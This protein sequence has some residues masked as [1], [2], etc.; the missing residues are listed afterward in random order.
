MENIIGRDEE[1]RR[2]WKILE[3]QSVVLASLRRIGKTY[4]LKKMAAEPQ[5]GWQTILF[6]VQGKKSVEEFVQGLFSELIEKGIVKPHANRVREFYNKWLGGRKPFGDYELPELKQHWKEVLGKML[7]DVAESQKPTLIMLDEFPWMLYELIV[8][9]HTEDE[10]MELLNILRTYR[11]L[12]EGRSKLRF[13]FCGSI[14]INVVLDH[15]VKE[16][17]YLGNPI[18]NMYTYV[19][20]EMGD[21]D[22]TE[23]CNYLGSMYDVKDSGGVFSFIAE[24]VQN[25][26][27]YIDLIFKELSQNGISI[28]SQ[29]D[30]EETVLELIQDIS[31]NGNFDHFRERIES[32]YSPEGRQLAYHL[33]KI[34]TLE[35]RALSRPEL[36]HLIRHENPAIEEDAL[37]DGLKNLARDLYLRM[38]ANGLYSFRYALLQRWWKMHY[39]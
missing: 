16:H 37:N 24:S 4:T 5:E 15:L 38:D 36:L 28:P 6:I 21:S 19:L 3:R 27:F 1:C 32:Y 34:A 33:L 23:L 7:E 20:E 18:N 13:I 31:G 9:H 2:L 35:D 12:H 17:K 8:T 26:P 22:A 10:C 39:C 11:E 25:L 30:I 29:S 14:G